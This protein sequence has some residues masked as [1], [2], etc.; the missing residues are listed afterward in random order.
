MPDVEREQTPATGVLRIFA[1]H[2]I[3]LFP[4]VRPYIMRVDFRQPG[5]RGECLVIARFEISERVDEEYPSAA[6]DAE[7]AAVAAEGLAPDFHADLFG[8][9]GHFI[10]A[11]LQ[12]H[13][14]HCP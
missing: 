1:T 10:K 14:R 3:D 5:Q 11:G 13:L 8:E 2:T 12:I 9:C 4:K 6:Q 7:P